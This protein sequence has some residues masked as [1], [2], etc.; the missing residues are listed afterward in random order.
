LSGEGAYPTSAGVGYFG[1]RGTEVAFTRQFSE[2][3]G[4]KT[5]TDNGDSE[6]SWAKMRHK[7]A[8]EPTVLSTSSEMQL[9]VTWQAIEKNGDWTSGNTHFQWTSKVVVPLT[10]NEQMTG[11]SGTVSNNDGNWSYGVQGDEARTCATVLAEASG[12]SPFPTA[13]F[14][15]TESKFQ[16]KYV[17]D[18]RLEIPEKATLGYAGIS[19][20]YRDERYKQKAFDLTWGSGS[21][22]NRGFDSLFTSNPPFSYKPTWRVQPND[23]NLV[24]LGTHVPHSAWNI[25]QIYGGGVTGG[26]TAYYLDATIEEMPA[27]RRF[28]Q[29]VLLAPGWGRD[30][31]DHHAALLRLWLRVPVKVTVT[32]TIYKP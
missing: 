3:G 28:F 1:H 16:Q 9:G 29:R 11:D 27:D 18:V 26:G 7:I 14:G 13:V 24:P 19:N 8:I 4:S 15:T 20:K 22:V 31:N 25:E 6:T 21:T 12:A 30:G 10:L 5:W 2:I 32:K 17:F 23:K